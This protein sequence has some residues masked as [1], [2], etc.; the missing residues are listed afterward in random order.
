[1]NSW[2]NSNLGNHVDLLTGYPFKSEQ[3]TD[4]AS[5]IRLLRGDN[6]AQGKLRWENAKKWPSSLAQGLEKY[7]LKRGD[8]VIAMDRTWIKAGLKIAP[9][10]EPDTPC[11]LVQRVARLRAKNDLDSYFLYLLLRSHKFEQY[12]KGVQTETA[13]PHI[14]ALQIQQYPITLPPL[15]EQTAIADLLSTWD[16]AIE[17]TEKLIA[18]KEKRYLWLLS[19]LISDKSYP[20]RLIRDFATEVSTRN[21][22]KVTGQVLSVTN[23]SGFVLPEDQFERRVAS[24]DLSNYK[25]V[26]RGQYAYNPSRINVGSIARLDDW[27]E[28]VLSPMYVVFELDEKKVDTD[29][30]LHWLSSHES[31]QRIKKSAQGSVRETVSFGDFAAIPFPLPPQ[32]EQQAIARTLNIAQHEITLMEELVDAYRQQ[33]HGLMQKLLTGQWWVKS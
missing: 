20:R 6:I 13:V 21:R 1:M 25:I 22:D 2:I 11:L 32:K 10:T 9:I 8:L 33:K 24:S 16:A 15:E 7:H 5:D 17:K 30:F 27:N 31:K 19:C 29:F 18:A 14:S 3:Y 28:G 12:V 23:H 4:N 26:R